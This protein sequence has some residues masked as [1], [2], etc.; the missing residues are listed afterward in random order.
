LPFIDNS[1][2]YSN[3]ESLDQAWVNLD[4]TAEG[5]NLSMKLINGMP[6]GIAW[7]SAL[8]ERSF[9]NVKKRLL[10]LYPGRYDLKIN[11]EQELLMVYLNLKLGEPTTEGSATIET[12]KSVMSYAG[13]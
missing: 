8:E 1:F 10:L 4:I 5:D 9:A 7:D 3:N 11:G 6:D 12:T 2:S 13:V